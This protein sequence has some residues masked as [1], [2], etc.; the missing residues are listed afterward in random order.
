MAVGV[1]DGRSAVIPITYLDFGERPLNVQQGDGFRK[2]STCLDA[3]QI[4]LRPPLYRC[5][6]HND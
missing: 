5:M 2:G 4:P 3:P 6:I 1:K